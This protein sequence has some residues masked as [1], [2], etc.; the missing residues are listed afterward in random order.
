MDST[1]SSRRSGLKPNVEYSSFAQEANNVMIEGADMNSLETGSVAP[2]F[3]LKNQQG[4]E[5]E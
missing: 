1:V 4:E 2:G 5:R 3:S